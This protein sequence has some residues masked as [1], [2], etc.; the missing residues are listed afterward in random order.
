MRQQSTRY[1][2][3]SW[4]RAESI[5]GDVQDAGLHAGLVDDALNGVARAGLE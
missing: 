3:G 5:R 4:G 2:W 1:L